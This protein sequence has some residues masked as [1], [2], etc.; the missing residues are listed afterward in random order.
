[1]VGGGAQGQRGHVI[2]HRNGI[3]GHGRVKLGGQRTLGGFQAL[4]VGVA[5][6]SGVAGGY[7]HAFR[8][9]F[10]Q[11]TFIGVHTLGGELEI[12]V[13]GLQRLE[14]QRDRESGGRLNIRGVIGN[15]HH[16]CAAVGGST[17]AGKILKHLGVVGKFGVQRADALTAAVV[18]KG[19]GDGVTDDDGGRAHP[20]AHR[21]GGGYG[22]DT[23]QA[24][25]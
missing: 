7:L 18:G 5:G 16:A 17:G 25:Q 13:T 23:Q 2:A 11:S 19:H 20:Y 12:A 6:Q 1:M 10:Q 14:I 4:Q 8:V 3:F 22:Q 24:H 15:L 9:V 21:A